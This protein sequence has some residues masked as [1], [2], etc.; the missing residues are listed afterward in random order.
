MGTWVV[1]KFGEIPVYQAV[2][3]SWLPGIVQGFSTRRGGV[4]QEPYDTF[5]VGLTCGDNPEH[6]FANRMRLADAIGV[7]L[8][9]LVFAEQ[10]HG[11]EVAVVDEVQ[12]VPVPGVDALITNRPGLILCMTYADCLPI[13]IVEPTKKV[14]ALVHSG[15]RGTA[16]NIV[17]RTT[18]AL[19]ERMEI[20]PRNCQV[21]IGPS[22]GC[23]NYEVGTEVAD[24]FRDTRGS[25]ASTTVMPKNEML[26]TWVLDLRAIAFLQLLHAGYRPQAIAVCDSDTYANDRDFFSHRRESQAGG[27]TGRMAGFLGIRE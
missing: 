17:Q 14:V 15:W 1:N 26:G 21:A 9:K 3:I 16:S 6:V 22:I 18:D 7:D 8:G 13:Y 12:S 27:K 5:N 11:S 24:F 20:D 2:T 4:S 19:K 10:V 25:G 23:D